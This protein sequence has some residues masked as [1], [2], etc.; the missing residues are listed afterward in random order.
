MTSSRSPGIN[1]TMSCTAPSPLRESAIRPLQVRE[2]R[3]F[4]APNLLPEPSCLQAPWCCPNKLAAKPRTPS[5]RR[6][7]SLT[8]ARC[9]RKIETAATT[10]HPIN[11]VQRV[12]ARFAS[13]ADHPR[14]DPAL[15]PT[16]GGH[17]PLAQN[18]LDLGS[19]RL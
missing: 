19:G 11:P 16:N 10:P 17:R 5:N 6:T 7:V 8:M 4:L 1:S 12:T 14:P 13:R 15:P 2:H 18:D 9:I 3:A